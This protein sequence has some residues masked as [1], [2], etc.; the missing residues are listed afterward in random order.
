MSSKNS[1][2]FKHHVLI[3][4]FIDKM[5]FRRDEKNIVLSNFGIYQT[6]VIIKSSYNNK[7]KGAL[8]QI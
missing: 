6:L 1:D 2:T 5:N 3:L 4:K 7:L 8:M